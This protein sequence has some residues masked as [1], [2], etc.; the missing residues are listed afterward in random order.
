MNKEIFYYAALYKFVE[1]SNLKNI[2]KQLYELCFQNNVFG[3]I[4]IAK[5]GLNGT[6]CSNYK[7]SS[8]P[9]SGSAASGML[10]FSWNSY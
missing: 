8:C 7:K 3:T 4:L 9:N 5:E 6:I 10:C 1:L 2:K